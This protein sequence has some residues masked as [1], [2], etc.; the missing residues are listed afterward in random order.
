MS[1]YKVLNKQVYSF[2]EYSIVPIRIEDRYDIMQWRNEQ[3]YHLRQDK[4]LTKENQDKYFDKVINKLFE[5]DK[6][7]QI[8]FSYLKND[9]CIGYGG[10]V[11]INWVDK[12][13]E[14]SFVMDTK[15]E[16]EGF[17][18]HWGLF[19]D[20]IE[21]IAFRELKFHK[22]F[23][24]AFDLRPH[25]YEALKLKNYKAE[26]TLKEHCFFN[27]IFIDVVIH[28]KINY[29]LEFIEAGLEH[30][31]LLFD[32]TNEKTVRINSLNTKPIK[33]EDHL[34]WFNEKLKSRQNHI[35]I[36]FSNSK[37]IGQVRLDL[38]DQVWLIDY[39]VDIDFRG[40]GLGTKILKKTINLET[41]NEF[42]AI[43]KEEN[44]ASIYVFKKLGF[45]PIKSINKEFKEFY[46]AKP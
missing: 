29:Q 14:V 16:T 27:D 6:P 17:V 22:L 12:N 2:G 39:S 41:F 18:K 44:K 10:L 37:P 28:S 24:Y 35:F 21:N 42:K 45:T 3:I 4:P 36:Y 31:K 38:E 23:T 34:K 11:H 1:F 5:E 19:L 9:E 46:Y 25:L 40:R 33:W 43:V 32:W 20:L 26:A 30:A 15:L 8:L 13:A 7:N